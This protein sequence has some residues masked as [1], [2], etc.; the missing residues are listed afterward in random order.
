MKI[1]RKRWTME[2]H[3]RCS[4]RSG[5]FL[6]KES[7][8]PSFVGSKRPRSSLGATNLRSGTLREA[9]RVRDT[10]VHGWAEVWRDQHPDLDVLGAWEESAVAERVFTMISYEG[11]YRAQPQASR[12]ELSTVVVE[13]LEKLVEIFRAR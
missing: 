1:V 12:W 11:I 5:R 13:F 2:C 3:E 7:R 10:V 8:N 9:D 6:R 4:L